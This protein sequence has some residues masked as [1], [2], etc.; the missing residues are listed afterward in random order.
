[1]SKTSLFQGVSK[2]LIVGNGLQQPHPLF[3]LSLALLAGHL[4]TCGRRLW[5]FLVFCQVSGYLVSSV[6]VAAGQHLIIMKPRK[7][8]GAMTDFGLASGAKIMAAY[9]SHFRSHAPNAVHDSQ[10]ETIGLVISSAQ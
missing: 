9:I 8:S 4:A 10:N 1:M 3:L 5:P 6:T 2:S 7:N